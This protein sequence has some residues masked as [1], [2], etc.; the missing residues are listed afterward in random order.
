MAKQKTA[1]ST[2]EDM[3]KKELLELCEKFGVKVSERATKEQIIKILKTNSENAVE[4]DA[5]GS[6]TEK[7]Q[8]TLTG[9]QKGKRTQLKLREEKREVAQTL[10]DDDIESTMH[11]MDRL[12]PRV[13]YGE[14]PKV[15]LEDPDAWK[16][17]PEFTDAERELAQS[18]SNPFFTLTGVVDGSGQTETLEDKDGNEQKFVF[19]KVMYKDI[20]VRIPSYLI[21]EDHGDE[22]KHPQNKLSTTWHHR[23]GQII[24]FNLLFVDDRRA[25][26]RYYGTCLPARKKAR[27]YTWYDRTSDGHYRL[28][29]GGFAE[30]RIVETWPDKLVLEVG[31]VE[32]TV[33]PNDIAKRLIKDIDTYPEY[34]PGEKVL[35]KVSNIKR[36]EVPLNTEGFNYPVS[37]KASIRAAEEN[38]QI[39]YYD[40]YDY[41]DVST[42]IVTRIDT[43]FQ[44]ENRMNDFYCE[45]K[46]RPVVI[47]CE[48]STGMISSGYLPK[49]GDEV[50]VRVI[51][52]DDDN[53]RLYGEIIRTKRIRK[54]N[55]IAFSV[56]R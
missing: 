44:R 16:K 2:F 11:G 6:E 27:C 55:D 41:G 12:T 50:S 37:F 43:D 10:Y 21:W 54:R 40:D 31:G 9:K 34:Q 52:K 7:P 53:Y 8:E 45:Y 14:K 5:A 51:K 49:E 3:K 33:Y 30:A 29:D 17:E 25:T 35:V 26:P 28:E 38:P 56:K 23:E 39:K 20:S 18:R 47:K 15:I 32:T 1:T 13:H 19:V 4:A 42:A 24:Q 46:N 22:K 48:P 36:E